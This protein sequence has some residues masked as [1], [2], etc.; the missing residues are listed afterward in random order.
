MRTSSIVLAAA[1]V[2]TA[3]VAD[4]KTK[5]AENS[6]QPP[7]GDSQ[8]QAPKDPKSYG[9]GEQPGTEAKRDGAQQ[10]SDPDR[11]KSP[12]PQ[13][14]RAS[15]GGGREQ[16]KGASVAGRIVSVSPD[17]VSVR[18]EDRKVQSLAV[19]PETVV[20]REGQRIDVS[21]LRPGEDVRASVER[22]G[23][24]RIATRITV[25][26]GDAPMQQG[27]T[28][29]ESVDTPDQEREGIGGHLEPTRPEPKGD[30]GAGTPGGS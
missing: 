27:T 21:R 30:R 23:E 13:D 4:E 25:G 3:A 18:G 17:S 19:T 15:P 2:A 8:K 14:Q 5:P 12:M 11:P 7:T 6:N 26:S 16:G 28:G 1:L 24:R 22:R 29:V 9:Y 10:A 20:S